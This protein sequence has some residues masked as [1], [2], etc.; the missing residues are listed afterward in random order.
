MM[1]FKA[2]L[3]NELT[4]LKCHKKYTVLLLL[5]IALSAV[6]GIL[7]FLAG[8]VKTL[9][10]TPVDTLSG[11]PMMLLGFFVSTIIPLIVFM[12][13][14]DLFTGEVADGTVRAG[15]MRPVSRFKQYFAKV[16]AV[17]VVAV[18]YL[19]AIFVFSELFRLIAVRSGSGIL[20]ELA[21]Y[22]LD[23]IPLIVL[24][25]FASMV[26]QF[27]KSTSLSVILCIIIYMGLLAG[28]VVISQ[29]S[30]LVFTGYMQWHTLWLG[31]GVPFGAML[32]K[33]FILIGYG[34][35][36]SCVGYYFFERKEA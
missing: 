20:T 12:A 10:I 31:Y 24:V 33:I 29:L 17:Y 15:F 9:P 4:K 22:A 5:S 23:C 16:S 35:V 11:L 28:G 27:L 3:K 14:C 25:L 2:S 34:L 26:N 8:Q 6:W 19:G 7:N 36:F 30:G 13:A 18:I 1:R 21:S 32:P